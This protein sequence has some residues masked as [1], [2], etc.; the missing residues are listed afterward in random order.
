M[1]GI[2]QMHNVK[3][4]SGIFSSFVCLRAIT[5]QNS[6]EFLPL[7]RPD[8]GSAQTDPLSPPRHLASWLAAPLSGVRNRRRQPQPSDS[9]KNCPEQLPRHRHLSQLEGGVPGVGNHLGPNLDQ[10]LPKCRQRPVLHRSRQCQPPQE[11]GQVVRQGKQLQ[12]NLV[13]FKA[14]AGQPRPVQRVLALLDPLLRRASMIVEV[15]HA[16]RANGQVR[17]IAPGATRP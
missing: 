14:V 15:D 1:F 8:Y 10:L 4:F 11:V 12:A 9:L 17:D 5:G 3:T 7:T 13:F 6:L 2:S 16:L